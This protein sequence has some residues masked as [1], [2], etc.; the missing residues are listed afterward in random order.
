VEG[1]I[2]R[3]FAVHESK[4][5]LKGMSVNKMSFTAFIGA[6]IFLWL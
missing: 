4:Q 1:S 3:S 6:V 2:E 5:F